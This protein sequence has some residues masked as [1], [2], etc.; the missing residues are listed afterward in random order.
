[1]DETCPACACE[2][3]VEMFEPFGPKDDSAPFR[4][5]LHCA[6]MFSPALAG[7][8]IT[9][10]A[11]SRRL[12]EPMPG[13]P[14][15]HLARLL[16]PS[17][18]IAMAGRPDIAVLESLK[19]GGAD[20]AAC[21]P[22]KKYVAECAINKIPARTTLPSREALPGKYD[23]IFVAGLLEF[24]ADPFAEITALKNHM[25]LDGQLRIETPSAKAL[26]VEQFGP[27]CSFFAPPAV[28]TLFTFD[29]LCLLLARAGFANVNLRRE[30]PPTLPA[31]FDRQP[32]PSKN[33]R[34]FARFIDSR[35]AE[36]S[37]LLVSARVE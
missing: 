18:S 11:W 5:C 34:R 20:V 32:Y 7:R 28:R 12:R 2:Q 29:G 10:D 19:R 14:V 8:E 1:M 13:D 26:V 6:T 16:G 30:T 33:A 17:P 15:R 23:L 24:V 22:E 3:T 36:R 25:T 35:R 21:D 31:L 27:R 9:Q 4:R 37:I